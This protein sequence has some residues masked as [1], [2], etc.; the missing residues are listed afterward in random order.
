MPSNDL[1]IA[2]QAIETGSML[3][4]FDKHFLHIPG[5]RLWN[6]I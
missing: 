6:K 2:S 5:L 4:T 3:I 1:W